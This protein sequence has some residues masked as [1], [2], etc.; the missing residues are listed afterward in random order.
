[1]SGPHLPLQAH[2]CS[3]DEAQILGWE[4]ME[5][6]LVS[7]LEV[8]V[9]SPVADRT[10]E[11]HQPAPSCLYW[12]PARI[13]NQLGLFRRPCSFLANS[14]FFLPLSSSLSG[15]SPS[16]LALFQGKTEIGW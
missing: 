1:M 5:V 6:L 3:P 2:G 14:K 9:M 12:P 15:K 16:V 13:H 7:S 8:G 10:S 11:T 4:L